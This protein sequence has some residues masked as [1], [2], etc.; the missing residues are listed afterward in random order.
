M[1]AKTPKKMLFWAKILGKKNVRAKKK[2][3]FDSLKNVCTK[4]ILFENF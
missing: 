1:F 3:L 2:I 4:K